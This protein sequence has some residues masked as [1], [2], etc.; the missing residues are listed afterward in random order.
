MDGIATAQEGFA[1]LTSG[2]GD[3]EKGESGEEGEE[4]QAATG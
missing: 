3:E 4:G 2:E 1:P